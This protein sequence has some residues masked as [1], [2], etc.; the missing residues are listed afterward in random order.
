VLKSSK[1]Q[2]TKGV[3]ERK[4]EFPKNKAGQPRKIEP[5]R[6]S[7]R[8]GHELSAMSTAGAKPQ[9]RPEQKDGSA[10]YADK[11]KKGTRVERGNVGTILTREVE[12]SETFVR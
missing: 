6:K 12:R 1:T 10:T 11:K 3:I 8:K 9:D 4:E 5:G 7:P 2:K